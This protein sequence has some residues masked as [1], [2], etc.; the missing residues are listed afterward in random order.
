MVGLYDTYTVAAILFTDC[1]FPNQTEKLRIDLDLGVLNRWM[2]MFCLNCL[3][4][5]AEVLLIYLPLKS[6][7]KPA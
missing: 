1:I 3:N 5:A 6:V 4:F 2:S 7:R